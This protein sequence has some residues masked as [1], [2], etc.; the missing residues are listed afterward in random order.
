MSNSNEKKITI[1]GQYPGLTSDEQAG[2]ED[3]LHRYL[4]VVARI[5]QHISDE[6]PEILTELRRSARL[7]KEKKAPR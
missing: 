4:T 3:M 5:Y 6:K 1:A 7:R 2:A